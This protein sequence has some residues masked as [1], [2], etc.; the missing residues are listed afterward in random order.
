MDH[1]CTLEI[2]TPFDIGPV[3][4]Y[5][6][7]GEELTLLDPGPATEDSYEALTEELDAS[8]FAM[9][10]V[11]QILVSH[12]HLDHFGIAHRIVEESGARVVAHRDATEQLVDPDT[13]LDREQA[14]FTPF[15]QEMGVPGDIVKTAVSLPEPY[16]DFREPVD[17]DRELTD[18]DIVD[19]RDEL[20][21]VHTPGHAPGSVCFVDQTESV[22]FTGD[23][24]L[25]H[26]SPNPLLTLVP[27]SDDE[28]TRS[29]PTYLGALRTL[30]ETAA[31]VGFTG[32]GRRV[33]DLPGRVD[34]IIGHHHD[35]KERISDMIAEMEPVT[36]YQIMQE[37][38]SDLPVTEVFPGMSE[39]IGHLD[40]LEDERRVDTT[41][42]K[43]S[44]RYS[45]TRD[46]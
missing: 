22:A 1:V 41:E 7:G 31:E 45:L 40:L 3:N 29:L 39:V 21:V 44:R 32:H 42:S 6:F 20:T 19:T 27:G 10:D 15:L 9:S 2:P 30:A 4:C 38:F 5:V 23:H 26:I 43:G 25:E 14:F 12:P 18:G 37:M 13:H 24:V 11:G 46:M 28:R 35:R 16:A 33:S 8:G 36:A 17:V 34:E